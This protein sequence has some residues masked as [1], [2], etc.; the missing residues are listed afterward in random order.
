MSKLLR[1][2]TAFSMLVVASVAANAAEKKLP[3]KAPPPAPMPPPF[4]WTGFYIG[5]N[6]GAAWAHHDFHD[7][8]F[9]ASFDDG[10]GNAVFIGGAQVGLNY[11]INQFVWG[12]EG[13]F[14][15]ASNNNSNGIAVLTPAGNVIRITS[16]DTRISTV[17]ARL[18]WTGWGTDRAMFYVKGGGGW[19]GNNGFT[20]TDVNTGLSVSTSGSNSRSGWLVGAGVEWAFTDTWSTKIE[21]DYLGLS[22]RTF[23][24]PV[25]SPFPRLVGDTFTTGNSNVQMLMVG[26]NYRFNWGGYPGRY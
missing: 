13:T 2:V 12:V 18:G 7:T 22:G 14:D 21:Y 11:Q 1:T 6:I 16:N 9:N 5:G 3:V 25:G 26:L 4:S 8:F 24:V 15:W 10:T 23:T 19:V 20:V 17:A